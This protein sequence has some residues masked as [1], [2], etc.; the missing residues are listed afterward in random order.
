MA[1]EYWS[2]VSRTSPASAPLKLSVSRRRP[3]C[4]I[5]DQG[6][7]PRVEVGEREVVQDGQEVQPVAC[8]VEGDAIQS[9]GSCGSSDLSTT[10]CRSD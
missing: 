3:V 7:E 10:G 9:A 2:G 8:F 6:S 5:T 1:P 4:A